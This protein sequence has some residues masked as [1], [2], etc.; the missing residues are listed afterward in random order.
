MDRD[1]P[2]PESDCADLIRVSRRVDVADAVG[3][4]AP[5]EVAL[6]VVAPRSFERGLP[7]LALCCLPGGYLTRRYYDLDAER[8]CT[9]RHSLGYAV[10]HCRT[11]G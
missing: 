4:P 3:L 8:P 9:C 10:P 1:P 5:C 11:A 2:E 6:D 7:P